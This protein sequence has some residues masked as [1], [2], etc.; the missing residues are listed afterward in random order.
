MFSRTGWIGVSEA[1]S[2]AK[3][4]Y[5]HI[6]SGKLELNEVRLGGLVGLG[7]DLG[8]ELG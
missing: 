2:A 7:V 5:S 1:A 6:Y 4:A 8:V 3:P